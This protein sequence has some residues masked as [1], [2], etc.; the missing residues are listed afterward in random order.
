MTT[1]TIKAEMYPFQATQENIELYDKIATEL[2]K[3]IIVIADKLKIPPSDIRISCDNLWDSMYRNQGMAVQIKSNSNTWDKA[4]PNNNQIMQTPNSEGVI[5]SR[6]DYS[7]DGIRNKE[8]RNL[9]NE[10][11]ELELDKVV[12]DY[13][14]YIASL[15]TPSEYKTIAA[16][17]PVIITGA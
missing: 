5:I 10:A 12:A 13:N 7:I 8:L 14:K 15:V 2:N 11:V 17:T 4:R 1:Q 16:N 9:L 6:S 3:F